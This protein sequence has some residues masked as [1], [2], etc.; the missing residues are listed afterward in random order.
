[1]KLS[2]K[3]T[4]DIEIQVHRVECGGGHAKVL[5]EKK[6]DANQQISLDNLY[7]THAY[8]LEIRK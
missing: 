8:S 7:I 5:L 2:N 6:S 4:I 1:M 3:I